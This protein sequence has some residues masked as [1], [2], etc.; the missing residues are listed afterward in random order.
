MLEALSSG[1]I[2]GSR[3][4]DLYP[5]VWSLW[6]TE[7]WWGTWSNEWFNHPTGQPWSPSTLIWGTLVIPFKGL[8][9]IHTLYNT[10]LLFN[11]ILGCVAFYMAGKSFGKN[12]HSGLLWMVT[13]AM[14]PLI[15]GFAV[16]GIFEGTQIWPLGLWIWA[17]QTHKYRMATLF[18]SVVLLSNWYWSLCWAILGLGLGLKEHRCPIWKSMLFSILLCSPWIWHFVQL[19]GSIDPISS[20]LY[21]SM[22]FQ[23]GIP[24]PN[25]MT[26]VNPFAQS[27]YIGWIVGGVY[28]YSIFRKQ[29]RL[30][31]FMVSM[32]FTL[33][34]GL[35]LLQEF[36]IVGSMRFPY[37]LHLLTL[38]GLCMGYSIVH[39]KQ[40]KLFVLGILIES[41][42]LSAIDLNIPKSPSTVPEYVHQIDG[43]VLELPGPL[44]RLPGDINP[45]KPRMRY[46]QYYQT[47]HERPSGWGLDFNGMVTGNDCFLGTSIVDPYSTEQE[48]TTPLDERC[49][50]EIDWVVLH[51]KNNALDEWLL[52][53]QFQQLSTTVP[54]VWQKV[55]NTHSK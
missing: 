15:H 26:A 55:H 48:K 29:H 49:W 6:A 21:R 16:E 41:T 9:P 38:I 1:D 14:N 30:S 46:I 7:S 51:T 8:V 45:S 28:L 42:M 53:N 10:S 4:T 2:V 25:A 17:V 43:T 12:H 36:P 13:I 27:N 24:I 33:S 54:V 19:E 35:P 37:R 3:F 47:I 18:G 32:G 11:R 50:K 23:F 22:G 40:Y 20:E 44:R 5:S 39:V 31:I 52:M 34:L